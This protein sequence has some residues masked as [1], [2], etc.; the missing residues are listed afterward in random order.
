MSRQ[1]ICYDWKLLGALLANEDEI[2]QADFFKALVKEMDNWGTTFQ[3]QSQLVWV[4]Q[5]L[6][7]KEK[8]ILSC[9]GHIGEN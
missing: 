1:G 3:K 9:L 6:T 4:N 2:T 7:D 8:D 5:R